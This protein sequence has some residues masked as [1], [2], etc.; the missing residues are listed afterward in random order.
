MKPQKHVR[1]HRKERDTRSAGEAIAIATGSQPPAEVVQ[2]CGVDIKSKGRDI[3]QAGMS[4]LRRPFTGT[5]KETTR[6]SAAATFS[7][8]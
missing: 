6:C 2:C 5:Q 8:A 7:V 1:K 4:N 3:I